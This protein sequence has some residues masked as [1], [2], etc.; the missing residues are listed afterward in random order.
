[1][2]FRVVLVENRTENGR[3]SRHSVLGPVFLNPLPFVP[4]LHPGI[5]RKEQTRSSKRHIRFLVVFLCRLLKPKSSPAYCVTDCSVPYCRTIDTAVR[6]GGTLVLLRRYH[7]GGGGPEATTRLRHVEHST[8]LAIMKILD[9]YGENVQK[10]LV[11]L[12]LTNIILFGRRLPAASK[13]FAA[14]HT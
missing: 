7:T 5:R 8:I 3:F 14:T 12:R 6:Q 9:L 11:N 2:P 10:I 13:K 1:M 4:G